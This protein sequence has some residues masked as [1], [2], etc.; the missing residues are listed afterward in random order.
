[1]NYQI[2]KHKY[3]HLS[4]DT[5]VDFKH[6]DEVLVRATP[7][8]VEIR[9]PIEIE[10]QDELQGFARL[11]TDAWKEHFRLKGTLIVLREVT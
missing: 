10:N 7:R 6:G 1:M 8:L 3:S 4:G 9:G 2:E 5:V 11:V